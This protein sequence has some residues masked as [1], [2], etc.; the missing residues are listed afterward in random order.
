MRLIGLVNFPDDTA[1]VLTS[2]LARL[3]FQTVRTDD[4]GELGTDGA[5]VFVW[6]EQADFLEAVRQ[7]RALH[8]KT[9][10]IVA[11]G[12]PDYGKWLDALEAGANDYCCMCQDAQKLGWMLLPEAQFMSSEPLLQQKR[13]PGSQTLQWV[14]SSRQLPDERNILTQ[15]Q[16]Q[17][18]VLAAGGGI[19]G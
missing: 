15:S 14:S 8:R 1:T 17:T 19:P 7:I 10:I 12:L 5:T 13:V 6:G 9:F 18:R 4:L 11:T 2:V 3:G 16:S